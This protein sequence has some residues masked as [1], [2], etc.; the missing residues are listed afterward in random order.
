MRAATSID[1]PSGSVPFDAAAPEI[2]S[3]DAAKGKEVP[4]DGLA[5]IDGDA[6]TLAA[7]VSG[8]SMGRSSGRLLVDGVGDAA[9]AVHDLDSDKPG[10]IA[11]GGDTVGVRDSDRDSE[12]MK[13]NVGDGDK[14]DD[15]DGVDDNDGDGDV[16]GDADSDGDN[17]DDDDDDD[18][19]EGDDDGGDDIDTDD[20]TDDEVE[21]DTADDTDSLA[22]CVS[23]SESDDEGVF[24]LD[25]DP[26]EDMQG[27]S[28]SVADVESEVVPDSDAEGFDEELTNAVPTNVALG[29]EEGEQA[30][31]T[32]LGG[33]TASATVKPD[34]E[35]LCCC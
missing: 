1:S 25:K 35:I 27:E 19:W 23:D 12:S 26:V 14:D 30:G 21:G 34:D 29:G 4:S 24:E 13:T 8:D 28:E 11:I 17:D 10:D 9:A 18:D 7:E 2:G 5:G 32:A 16:V 31:E 15:G 3:A 6:G 33:G 20:D 22:D